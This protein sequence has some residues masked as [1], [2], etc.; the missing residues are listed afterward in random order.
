MVID[1]F[2]TIES[3]GNPLQVRVTPRAAANRLKI[4]HNPDG[5]KLIRAY[6]TVPPEDGKANQEVIVLLSKALGLSK[7]SFTI[8]RGLKSRNKTILIAKSD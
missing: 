1:L 3:L 4:E 5:T 8:I 6:V 2:N 7:S